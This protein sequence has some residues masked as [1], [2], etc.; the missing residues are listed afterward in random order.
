MAVVEKESKVIVKTTNYNPEHKETLQNIQFE[1]ILTYMYT[2]YYTQ[3][4]YQEAQINQGAFTPKQF[5]HDFLPAVLSMEH[6]DKPGN[7]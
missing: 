6:N 3:F 1:R 2:V 4:V 5:V 7:K